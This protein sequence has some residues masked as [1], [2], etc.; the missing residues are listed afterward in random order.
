MGEVT[1]QVPA[2]HVEDFRAALAYELGQEAGYVADERKKF[3]EA[4]A[5]GRENASDGD[6]RGA[7]KLLT[8]DAEMFVQAGFE[9]TGPIEISM[10]D[11]GGVV[12]FACETVARKIVGPQLAEALDCGP[13]DSDYAPKLR[14]LVDRL[15]WAIDQAEAVNTSYFSDRKPV[16]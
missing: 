15:T 12:A 9:G 16:A 10:E 7:M 4:L 14:E 3:C 1:L 5:W 8:R 13:F 2:E 11:E 6:L